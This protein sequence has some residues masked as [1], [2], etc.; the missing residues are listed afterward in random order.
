MD[1]EPMK[2][3]YGEMM[4][5]YSEKIETPPASIGDAQRVVISETRSSMSS[6]E[7]CVK[8]TPAGNLI[9]TDSWVR[10]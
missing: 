4:G 7:V 9:M 8:V 10:L 6:Y 5:T 1:V 3:Y 2:A